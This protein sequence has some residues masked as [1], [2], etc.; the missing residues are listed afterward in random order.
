VWAVVL[1]AVFVGDGSLLIRCADLF[2]RGG[3]L[4]V[5]VVTS[6]ARVADWARREAISVVDWPERG[7]PDLDAF[8][9]DYLLSIAN[10]RL[11]PS[12]CWGEQNGA[13]SISTTRCCRPMP[14]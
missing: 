7:T 14:G 1:R 5:G 6:S 9:F 4:V 12:K 10:L 13:P 2:S 11:S 8:E 3:G